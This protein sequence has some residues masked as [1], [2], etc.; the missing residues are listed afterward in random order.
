MPNKRNGKSEPD[1]AVFISARQVCQR[2]GGLSFMWLERKLE[3]DATFPPPHKFGGRRFFKV[4]DLIAWE[5]A[6]AVRRRPRKT[7]HAEARA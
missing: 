1:D 5:R 4:A 6:A 2:Y 7:N 3:K